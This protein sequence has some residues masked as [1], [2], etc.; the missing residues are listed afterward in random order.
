[1]RMSVSGST[2]AAPPSRREQDRSAQVGTQTVVF[3][4]RLALTVILGLSAFL[5]L[6]QLTREGYGNTY[7]AAT[8]K[9]MLTSWRNFFFLSSDA[10]FVTVDKPPLG[11]WIQAASAKCSASM[12]GAS[13]CPKQSL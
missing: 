6:F 3:W 1:M 4:Q 13:C 11:F 12:D 10:G 9:N 2:I 8:V 7:Y 5:N